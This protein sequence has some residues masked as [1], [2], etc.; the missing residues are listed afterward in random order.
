MPTIEETFKNLGF[1]SSL[2]IKSNDLDHS[3]SDLVQVG[4]GKTSQSST[5]QFRIFPTSFLT[6]SM[7]S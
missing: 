4:S 5:Q 3:K 7:N 1:P 2:Q 6:K